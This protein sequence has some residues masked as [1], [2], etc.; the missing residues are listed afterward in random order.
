MAEKVNFYSYFFENNEFL[1]FTFFS[2]NDEKL[3]K[4]TKEVRKKTFISKTI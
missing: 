3:E 2:R 1:T 4:T